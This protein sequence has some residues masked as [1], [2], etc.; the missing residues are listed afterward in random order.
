MYILMKQFN[1]YQIDKEHSNPQKSQHW[2][3]PP[4]AKELLAADGCWKRELSPLPTGM[5]PLI[6]CPCSSGQ[7]LDS[8]GLDCVHEVV[9]EKSWGDMNR[10]RGEGRFRGWMDKNILYMYKILK[11]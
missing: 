9:R 8:E 2:L 1:V 11:Q 4:L 6:A 5:W 3:I 7:P 10:P